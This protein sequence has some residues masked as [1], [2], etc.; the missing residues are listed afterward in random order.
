M[1]TKK[2]FLWINIFL[3]LPIASGLYLMLDSVMDIKWYYS[4]GFSIFFWLYD[5]TKESG[6]NYLQYQID[7]LKKN[8]T[9]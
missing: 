5:S 7:E 3:S 1:K 6:I 4:I 8:Q 9:V 2:D